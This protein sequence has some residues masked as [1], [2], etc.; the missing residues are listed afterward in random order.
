MEGEF[1]PRLAVGLQKACS[2]S[3]EGDGHAEHDPDR[4]HL[5]N[6]PA[7]AGVTERP[8]GLRRSRLEFAGD[9]WDAAEQ[10]H[11]T[12]LLRTRGTAGLRARAS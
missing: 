7:Q 5:P 4:R 2:E 12:P 3:G 6:E 1:A 11:L 8:G 9:D 10:A